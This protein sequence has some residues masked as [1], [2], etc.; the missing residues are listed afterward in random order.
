MKRKP[1]TL[2]LDADLY[3]ALSTLSSH[4][5]RSMNDLA[6]EA[7]SKLVTVENEAVARDLER[8]AAKLRAYARK[9]PDFEKAIAAFAEAESEFDDPAEGMPT[10]VGDAARRHVRALLTD[11]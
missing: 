2:R 11:G 9:D 10:V 3:E 6:T 1:F 7:V 8:T 4:V 5:H